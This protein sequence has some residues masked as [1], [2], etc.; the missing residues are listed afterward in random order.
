[1]AF[2]LDEYEDKG[3]KA[4]PVVLLL[5][6]SGSMQATLG[7]ATKI[8]KL[9]E[10]VKNMMQFFQDECD[11]ENFIKVTV[12]TFDSTVQQIGEVNADPGEFLQHYQPITAQ[13]MTCL[14]AALD[15]AKELIENKEMIPG[16]WY[17][18]A[19]VLVSDGAPNDNW[20]EP[21]KRFIRE[22][23]SARTQRFAIAIGADGARQKDILS[24]FTGSEENVL[25]AENAEDIVKQFQCVTMSVST[26]VRSVNPDDKTF[27]NLGDLLKND[28]SDFIVRTRSNAAGTD[29]RGRNR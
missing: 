24:C 13:G 27:I 18:P 29:R 20:T 2:N 19:V 7:N 12:F 8:D 25:Y 28:V 17:K 16:R 3:I 1:M 21:M 14:G 6:T 23:R 10:A 22:K 11:R 4:L 26:R 9:N 5:D 15:K